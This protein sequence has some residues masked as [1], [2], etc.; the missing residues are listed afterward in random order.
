MR[1]TKSTVVALSTVAALLTTGGVATAVATTGAGNPGPRA[2]HAPKGDGSKRLCKRAPK[3]DKRIDRVQRRL[4]GDVRTR[5]S[6]DRLE[7]R[8]GNAK[9]AGHGVI[10]DFLDDRLGDRRELKVRLGE[11]EDGLKKVRAWCA[12]QVNG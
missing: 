5:G 3:L 2:N 12:K 10:A 1:R 4:D 6:I 8:V 11:R 9:K 7:R